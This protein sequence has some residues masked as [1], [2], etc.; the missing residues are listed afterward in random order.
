[1]NLKKIIC[2]ILSFTGVSFANV[3]QNQG[4][5]DNEQF[6][7]FQEMNLY[8]SVGID[9]QGKEEFRL[10]ESK[11]Y[12]NI[13]N[14]LAKAQGVTKVNIGDV[15]MRTKNLIALGKEIYTIVE[16]G[17]AVVTINS[18]PIQVLPMNDNAEAISASE[19]DGWSPP[20]SRKFRVETKNYMGMSPVVF[21]FMLIFTYG[22]SLEGQGL[23]ITGAQIKPVFVDV[24]WGF[25]F[26]AS[27]KVQT[28]VNEGS[29][30]QPIAGAVLMLD[31]KIETILQERQMNQTFY[32]NGQGLINAH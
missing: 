28:I 6:Y 1:M 19:L 23:Y 29:Y 3:E 20:K 25:K 32:I 24:K 31:T 13:F 10:V 7:A 21:E 15:L 9:E 14:A 5:S 22:G 26:D 27:F 11:P 8:E 2:I 30:E 18:K 16:A 17:K 12:G 4:S